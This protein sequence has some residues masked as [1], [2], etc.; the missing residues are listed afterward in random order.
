MNIFAMK[1]DRIDHVLTVGNIEVSCEFYSRVL[2]MQVV[3]FGGESIALQFGQQKINLHQ[4][5]IELE[6]KARKPTLGSAD[7]CLLISIPLSYAIASIQSCL[8]EIIALP[9]QRTGATGAILPIYIRDP[10]GNLI[11]ILNLIDRV[12]DR[13]SN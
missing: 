12:G 3:T 4:A 9:V 2:G 1:V 5:S 8:G 11:E 10:D 13:H 7:F 6:P